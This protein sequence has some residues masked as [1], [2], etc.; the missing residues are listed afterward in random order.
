MPLIKSSASTHYTTLVAIT[1]LLSEIM[2]SCSYYKEKKLVYI[3]II[4]PSNR[5]SFFYIKCIKLNIYL[6]Y[7]IKLV[8]KH[9]A[10]IV[11]VILSL[12]KIM[13]IYSCCTEKK[14]VYIIITALFNY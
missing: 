13:P 14:L 7:N 8:S 2:P 9:Y 6:S 10:Y 5:Q 1:L 11:A 3:T 12:S 4:V